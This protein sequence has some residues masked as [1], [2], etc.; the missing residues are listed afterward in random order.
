MEI[1]KSGIFY[2]KKKKGFKSNHLEFILF[3]V[4]SGR[5]VFKENNIYII[6]FVTSMYVKSNHLNK[7]QFFF[8]FFFESVKKSML[9]GISDTYTTHDLLNH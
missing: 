5:F 7:L 3:L 8:F 1:R 2:L 9:E 6:N 4:K